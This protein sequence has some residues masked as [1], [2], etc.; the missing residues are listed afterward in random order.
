MKENKYAIK[1]TDNVITKSYNTYTHA[2]VRWDD[3]KQK[4]F[5]VHA[6]GSY[7]NAVKA[8]NGHKNMSGLEIVELVTV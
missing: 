2:V 3:E 7:A 8:M 1:G 6:C 4:H 5:R